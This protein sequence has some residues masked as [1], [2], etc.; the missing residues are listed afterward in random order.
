MFYSRCE[1]HAQG[2]YKALS[3]WELN[4]Q[5]IDCKSNALPQRH[6]TI[7][8]VSSSI[9]TDLL[10]YWFRQL[11]TLVMLIEGKLND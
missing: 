4:I 3:Q 8:G 2:C 1:Q 10:M 5:P 7:Y 9:G 6:Y 11:L